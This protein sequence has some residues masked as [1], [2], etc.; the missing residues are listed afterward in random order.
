M[1]V[2][3]VDD[4][5]YKESQTTQT[6]TVTD[7]ALSPADFMQIKNLL[8][9]GAELMSQGH[10]Q[11]AIVCF[12]QGIEQLGY[13]YFS[14]RLLDDTDMKL[15]LGNIEQERGNIERAAHL[16]YNVLASRV[17]VYEDLYPKKGAA[18]GKVAQ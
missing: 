2:V 17:Q 11:H 15:I 13:R 12:D 9:Q 10:F 4:V 3:P 8:E 16:K 18:Q 7:A 14:D 5:L 6:I 1:D